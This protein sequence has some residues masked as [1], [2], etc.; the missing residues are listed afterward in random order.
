MTCGRIC[1]NS[2]GPTACPTLCRHQPDFRCST[3]MRLAESARSSMTCPSKPVGSRFGCWTGTVVAEDKSLNQMTPPR[4]TSTTSP[5]KQIS[6]FP[7]PSSRR[8]KPFG[9]RVHGRNRRGVTLVKRDGSTGV[10][11]YTMAYRQGCLRICS[12]SKKRSRW[13][14]SRPK[15]SLSFTKHGTKK[16]STYSTGL[17]DNS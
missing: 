14:S 10:G 17:E 11:S 9:N 1:S 13:N 4:K 16:S 2:T 5:N 8:A 12:A 6:S 3:G 15:K 7:R